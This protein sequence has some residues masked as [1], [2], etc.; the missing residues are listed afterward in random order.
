MQT[1]LCIILGQR[2]QVY[3]ESFTDWSSFYDYCKKWSA[4]RPQ[5]PFY[6]FGNGDGFQ[7]G[8]TFRL[9][10]FGAGVQPVAH[11]NKATLSR[12][13][14]TTNSYVALITLD[15]V[16]KCLD[17]LNFIYQNGTPEHK[18]AIAALQIDAVFTNSDGGIS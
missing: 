3:L 11:R 9:Q 5:N 6:V 14:P 2:V 17:Y 12:Y 16:Q 10:W 7:H 13:N 4:Q 8:T 1:P 15:T 18:A